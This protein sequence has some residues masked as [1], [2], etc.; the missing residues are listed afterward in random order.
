MT[1]LLA[2]INSLPAAVYTTDAYGRITSFN[3]AAVTFSGRVPQLGTDSWCVSWK[4]YRP[5]GTPLPHEE[6]PMAIALKEGRPIRGAEAI[7]ERPDGTRV[8]FEPYPT[9][10]FDRTG[11]LL[12][13]VNM[14]VDITQRKKAEDAVRRA[15]QELRDFVEQASVG[16]HW[17]GS[18]GIIL[19]ANQAELDML[20]YA[21]DAYVG[22]HIAE[23]H[24][25]QQVIEDILRRLAHGEAL[26]GYPARLRRNDGSIRDVLLN[27]NVLWDGGRFVHTRCFTFDIT[28]R[29]RAEEANLRLAAIVES[30]DDAI[31]GTDLNSIIVS[32]NKGAERL[33]GY[34]APEAIGRSVTMLFPPDSRDDETALMSRI[35]L[36]QKI[37]HY[38]TVRRRKDG[39]LLDISLTVSPITDSSGNV[40]GASKIARDITP[41]KQADEALRKSEQ[42]LKQSQAELQDKIADLESF[43]D[44]AVARELKLMELEKEVERL[45]REAAASGKKVIKS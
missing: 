32:W 15:E 42:R 36:G 17:V 13:A 6:C 24:A 11:K 27:S 43:Q 44:I 16:M 39:R 19:W 4:L 35:L 21:H 40:I 23:F 3:H 33:Y 10:L 30:S 22:H 2:V 31:I 34:S 12:G 37:E 41:R 20:G 26:Q 25:D 45:R 1:W 18:D 8:H 9:P 5:D 28:D 38:E 14:L 7:A 29:K